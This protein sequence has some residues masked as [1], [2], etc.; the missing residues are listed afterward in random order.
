MRLTL[1]PGS[2]RKTSTEGGKLDGSRLRHVV[3]GWK[4]GT[5]EQKQGFWV[6][7]GGAMWTQKGSS[8]T[9]R[10]SHAISCL[11]PGALVHGSAVIGDWSVPSGPR[12]TLSFLPQPA[13]SSVASSAPLSC[14]PI[15]TEF[16]WQRE[17]AAKQLTSWHDGSLRFLPENYVL[18]DRG[19]ILKD[20]VIKS[21]SSF[22]SLHI[23]T[24]KW[25]RYLKHKQ[26][27]SQTTTFWGD[28]IRSFLRN[29]VT[30]WQTKAMMLSNRIWLFGPEVVTL[31]PGFL[32]R[33]WQYDD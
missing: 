13:F 21:S 11:A 2:S 29:V 25:Y 18:K 22:P 8:E 27:Q 15:G 26:K 6:R 20:R 4:L 33:D 19:L 32:I 1:K 31:R 14:C 24:K 28:V 9:L 17:G 7:C 3:L 30:F 16:L 23:H 5:A 10:Q 12:I